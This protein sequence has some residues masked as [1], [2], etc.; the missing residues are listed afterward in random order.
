M[1]PD[2]MERRWD[3]V[4]EMTRDKDGLRERIISKVVPRERRSESHLMRGGDRR[5]E[6][7]IR[8]TKSYRGGGEQKVPKTHPHKCV[9][10]RGI[11]NHVCLHT[12]IC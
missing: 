5:R 3:R 10:G 9:L 7:G 4:T 6:P 2:R 11:V 1:G 12:Y 8:H